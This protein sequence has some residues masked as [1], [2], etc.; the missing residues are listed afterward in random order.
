[1]KILR[2]GR[3]KL[4]VLV[5]V[6]VLL[7][8]CALLGWLLLK[9]K[10]TEQVPTSTEQTE[11]PLNEAPALNDYT[12]PSI[13]QII[14]DAPNPE[15]AAI[16]LITYGQLKETVQK[17]DDAIALFEG[18]ARLEGIPL[19]T[20]QTALA[21]VYRAAEKAGN[22]AKQEEVRTKLGEEAFNAYIVK[23]YREDQ[24]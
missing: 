17:Y 14:K 8:A 18:V 2:L 13:D 6:I 7:V 15:E 12:F 3:R 11:L 19:T 10:K 23:S 20:Q 1:M 24:R 4:I 21:G 9:D 5:L 16:T 22:T